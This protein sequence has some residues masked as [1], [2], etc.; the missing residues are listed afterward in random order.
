MPS[1]PR[2]SRT[3]TVT[4]ADG[5][6][7][8]SKCFLTLGRRVHR[9]EEQIALEEE[10]DQ[11]EGLA[12]CSSDTPVETVDAESQTE[13]ILA[14]IKKWENTARAETQVRPLID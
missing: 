8:L 10:T 9:I 7:N 14:S 5:A 6:S 4:C 12:P 1:L 3:Y 11:D 13:K 2:D